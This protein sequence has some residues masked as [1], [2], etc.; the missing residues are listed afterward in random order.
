MVTLSYIALF[1]INL[2]YMR[3][4][5]WGGTHMGRGVANL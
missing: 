2:G 1:E 5:R 4:G 3:P